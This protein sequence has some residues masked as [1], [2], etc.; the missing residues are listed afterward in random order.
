MILLPLA[1]PAGRLAA[2]LLQF[3][4]GSVGTPK[5]FWLALIEQ[6]KLI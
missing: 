3:A 5:S 6:K 2:K 4:I 1:A